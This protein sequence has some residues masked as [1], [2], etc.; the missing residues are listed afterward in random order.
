MAEEINTV[1]EF[2][3]RFLDMFE[4]SME[5]YMRIQN[6]MHW[7]VRSALHE[8]TLTALV[9]AAEELLKKY[10]YQGKYPPD[11][12]AAKTIADISAAIHSRS[13]AAMTPE[14]KKNLIISLITDAIS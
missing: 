7:T 14:E 3:D 11:I 9:P 4:E 12:A 2:A 13:Y 8:R 10:G 6:S 1:E 5:K